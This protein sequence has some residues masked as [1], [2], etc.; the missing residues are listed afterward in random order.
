VS[1]LRGGGLRDRLAEIEAILLARPLPAQ[2]NWSIPETLDD[3][4]RENREHG[5]G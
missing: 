1:R 2:R 3:L 4:R 5:H